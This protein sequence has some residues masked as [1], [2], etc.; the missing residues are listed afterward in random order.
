MC[1]DLLDCSTLECACEPR[2]SYRRVAGNRCLTYT[3]PIQNPV[4]FVFWHFSVIFKAFKTQR[5]LS[6][7]LSKLGVVLKDQPI[8]LYMV[9][10][11]DIRLLT[12]IHCTISIGIKSDQG[13][14]RIEQLSSAPT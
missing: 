12:S 11:V 2:V 3:S 10:V 6:E 9:S 1:S 7:R 14:R 8:T 13:Y 4:T 5:D